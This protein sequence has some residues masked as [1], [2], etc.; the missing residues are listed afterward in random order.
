MTARQRIAPMDFT[1]EKPDYVTILYLGKEVGRF[2]PISD[3]LEVKGEAYLEGASKTVNKVLNTY[4]FE[5][6]V[7][8]HF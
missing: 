4:Q 3:V 6:N 1:L 7:V 8:P 5:V 2:Y